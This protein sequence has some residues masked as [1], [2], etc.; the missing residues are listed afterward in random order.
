MKTFLP[1][2]GCT[3]IKIIQADWRQPGFPGN[4][5][6][7]NVAPGQVGFSGERGS[8]LYGCIE[9]DGDEYEF[10]AQGRDGRPL[11]D[12]KHKLWVGGREIESDG[13]CPVFV[14]LRL[15]IIDYCKYDV[16]SPFSGLQQR[17]DKLN[18]GMRERKNGWSITH[19]RK[20]IAQV[21]SRHEIVEKLNN[22]EGW[23][24]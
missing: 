6:S 11:I 14:T 19:D 18:L 5:S 23:Q 1:S 22:N 24:V 3:D 20:V 2:G 8:E 17:M 21:A 16:A 9:I 7:D 12:G 13:W 10:V 4:P 15:E